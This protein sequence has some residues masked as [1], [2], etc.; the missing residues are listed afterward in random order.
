[1][2]L[3]DPKSH[4]NKWQLGIVE[5]ATPEKDGRRRVRKVQIR[6]SRNGMSKTYRRPMTEFVHGL[7]DGDAST[8]T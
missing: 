5:N 1:M 3:R 6:A 2:L 4:R 7:N 8:V